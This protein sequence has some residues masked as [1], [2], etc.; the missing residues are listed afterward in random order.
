M[1]TL[2]IS[3]HIETASAG[4]QI[5]ALLEQIR[6]DVTTF[7]PGGISAYSKHASKCTAIAAR[8]DVAAAQIEVAS[9]PKNSA[10]IPLPELSTSAMLALFAISDA[11]LP[12]AST[13]LGVSGI[14]VSNNAPS[15]RAVICV[16]PDSAMSRRR[17]VRAEPTP[18]NSSG[19]SICWYES[20]DYYMIQST[21]LDKREIKIEVCKR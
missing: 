1:R 3:S 19:A 18:P 20:L 12:Y 21:D 10:N 15:L 6:K 2:T 13:S 16:E 8:P 9:G 5:L 7:L 14:I 17:V 4:G 11:L